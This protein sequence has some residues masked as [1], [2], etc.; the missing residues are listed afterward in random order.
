MDALGYTL[1][2]S[3]EVSSKL[4]EIAM[5]KY[6]LAEK[7]HEKKQK[8]QADSFELFKYTSTGMN[9]DLMGN[10][11]GHNDLVRAASEE[12][13][14]T[15]NYQAGKQLY[16]NNSGML[17]MLGKMS[18][19]DD[20]LVKENI[21]NYEAIKKTAGDRGKED[22]V[23][24]G[25]NI[26]NFISLDNA[27]KEDYDRVRTK[28]KIPTFI[29]DETLR[30]LVRRDLWGDKE[31]VKFNADAVKWE[32]AA[33][34]GTSSMDVVKQP[35]G[36]IKKEEGRDVQ[37]FKSTKKV[38]EKSLDAEM[39]AYWDGVVKSGVAVGKPLKTPF[40]KEYINKDPKLAEEYAKDPI[41]T[42]QKIKSMW[43]KEPETRARLLKNITTE[44]EITKQILG[45]S[46]GDGWGE[47]KSVSIKNDKAEA[48]GTTQDKTTGDIRYKGKLVG[49]IAVTNFNYT[50]A[51]S[52][53]NYYI[54]TPL[55][56]KT[57]N[58]IKSGKNITLSPNEEKNI[59]PQRIEYHNSID[60]NGNPYVARVL[61]G[62]M[63]ET[64]PNDASK[65]TEKKVR[66]NMSQNPMVETKIKQLLNINDKKWEDVQS[67]AISRLNISNKS[68]SGNT[69]K[70]PTL[71]ESGL[72]TAEY[73]KKYP[74]K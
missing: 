59:Q 68:K 31:L 54:L 55:E 42:E 26:K 49:G 74:N 38:N 45:E 24:S 6:K 58:D 56:N 57:V 9:S 29:S 34:Y 46:K 11:K 39:D 27:K 41:A 18:D 25:E 30:P 69:S 61:I 12:A 60:Y 21:K 51:E 5:M 23:Q 36:G 43:K 2:P 17:D 37:Y 48:Y 66:I 16:L 40:I 4:P 50:K 32:D 73:R 15:G 8:E 67:D 65:F 14:K 62:I 3:S 63:K 35:Y 1:L 47:D 22:L 72:S 28:Y 64:D 70:I 13:Q 7:Q 53:G 71:L 52:K 10:E 44:D 33:N 20:K 19:S